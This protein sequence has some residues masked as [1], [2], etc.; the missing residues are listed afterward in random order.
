MLSAEIEPRS[1][2]P[3]CGGS[4]SAGVLERPKVPVILNRFYSNAETARRAA[5]GR[6]SIVACDAC[7]FVFNRSF[8]P[9]IML[10]D[11]AYEN[12]QSS[13]RIF[14]AHMSL[15]AS[16]LITSCQDSEKFKVVEIGCGQGK[17][18]ELLLSK[19]G[20]RMSGAVGYDPAWRG[21]PRSGEPEPK[22]LRLLK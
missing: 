2:C 11:P 5:T 7:G 22:A 8:N 17:F 19:A 20:D 12:D 13:S 1:T 10:Y 6:L 3:L 15:M 9:E 16:R 14:S 18:L 21:R 4:S